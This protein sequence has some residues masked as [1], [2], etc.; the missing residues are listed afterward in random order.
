METF[1]EWLDR[2]EREA[3]GTVP[4]LTP[5]EFPELCKLMA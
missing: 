5:E 3:E 2:L 1:E 4:N